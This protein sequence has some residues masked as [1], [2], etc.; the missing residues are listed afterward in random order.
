MANNEAAIDAQQTTPL[1]GVKTILKALWDKDAPSDLVPMLHGPAGTGKTSIVY[2]VAQE[3]E[4]ERVVMI[5]AAEM[6]PEDLTGPP[7]PY[8]EGYSQ[9][10]PPMVLLQLTKEWHER[11]KAEHEQLVKEGKAKGEYQMPGP[12]VI[13][14]D[15]LPNA[16]PDVQATLHS[17][18]QDRTFGVENFTLLDNVRLV[19]A[20]NRREDGAHV[21][22]M[23]APLRTRFAPHLVVRPSPEEWVQWARKNEVHPA[24]IAFLPQHEELFHDFDPK[25]KAMTY[26]N[27]RTWEKASTLL[28]QFEAAGVPENELRIALEGTIGT[29]PTSE[30]MHF[31]DTARNAPTAEE[32]SK[33]PE[34]IDTFHD[35]PDIALVCV[36]NM[37]NAARRKSEW[38]KSFI[39]Y[40]QRMHEQY[41]EMLFP[42][43]LNLDGDMPRETIMEVL[44]AGDDLAAVMETSD[45]L[46]R[47]L[48]EGDEAKK[49]QGNLK[50]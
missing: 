27:F 4:Y 24:I 19:A 34:G 48:E 5:R 41:R 16:H 26:A 7:F 32:I 46:R 13:F 23:S 44:D 36:E 30:F 6:R 39:K 8:E 21:Y 14:M 40:G 28:K 42:V 1:T 29:G 35:D 18:I 15:E 45:N 9:F 49:S 33:D 2:Q 17:L 38:V 25:S 10:H 22:E 37:I 31:L 50:L 43:L 47:I 12:S 20:G 11:K 3:L